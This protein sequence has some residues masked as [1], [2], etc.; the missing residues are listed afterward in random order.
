MTAKQFNLPFLGSV[1]LDPRVREG[2]DRGMPAALGSESLRAQEFAAIAAKVVERAKEVA[3]K[4][5]DV[6]EIS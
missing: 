5:E 4:N 1:D 6:L 2:G 3:A